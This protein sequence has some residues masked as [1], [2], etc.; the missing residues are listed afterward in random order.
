LHEKYLVPNVVISSIPLKRWLIDALP[1]RIRPADDADY[2]L[3]VTSLL[4][5]SKDATTSVVH[6]YAIPVLPGCFHGVG[7]LFSALTLGHLDDGNLPSAPP[8]QTSLSRAVALALVKTRGILLLTH[9][10]VQTLPEPDRQ[11]P[12]VEKDKADPLRKS[13]RLKGCELRIIQGQDIV[14]GNTQEVGWM[15]A[16]DE[17]WKT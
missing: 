14:R 4:E 12:D 9:E 16:W 11:E 15:H 13:R 10:Y 3:C 17:F 6:A 8:G 1:A 7:D 5:K 2:L